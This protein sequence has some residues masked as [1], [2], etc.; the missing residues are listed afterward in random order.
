MIK[1][2]VGDTV[3]LISGGPWMTVHC[4][5]S[6]STDSDTINVVWFHENI[7]HSSVFD[8]RT[9]VHAKNSS[10]HKN[11]NSRVEVLDEG[12]SVIGRQG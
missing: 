11:S 3:R 9:L 7:V 10:I 2:E 5:Q 4:V 8:S 12:G 6:F 1:F